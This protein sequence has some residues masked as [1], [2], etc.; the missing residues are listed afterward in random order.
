MSIARFSYFF[1]IVLLLLGGLTAEVYAQN[2]GNVK[3]YIDSDRYKNSSYKSK[4]NKGSSNKSQKARGSNG[5]SQ[6][7]AQAR[8]MH[9]G[10]VLSV[11]HASS[12]GSYSVYIVKMLTSA[13]VVKNVRVR[14]RE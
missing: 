14:V 2:S 3:T 1:L 6:A 8:K 5:L 13:G 7:I 12:A 4:A 9:A 11:R 10:E